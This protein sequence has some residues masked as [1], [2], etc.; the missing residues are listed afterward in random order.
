[1]SEKSLLKVFLND[2]P[3]VP[4]DKLSLHMYETSTDVIFHTVDHVL[5]DAQL[6]S[7]NFLSKDVS[8]R[9]FKFE[10]NKP[11]TLYSIPSDPVLTFH[12]QVYNSQK[13]KF[14]QEDKG[15]LLFE[16]NN[17]I[18]WQNMETVKYEFEQGLFS[19]FN[20]FFRPH[21]ILELAEKHPVLR[22]LA[23]E[24]ATSKRT[25]LDFF[26]TVAG[27]DIDVLIDQIYDEFHQAFVSERRFK[28]LAECLL[29]C[30][31]GID[32]TVDPPAPGDIKKDDEFLDLESDV[33]GILAR[34]ELFT[35]DQKHF[36]AQYKY[37]TKQML[38]DDFNLKKQAYIQ[39]KK[40]VRIKQ[41][42]L[43]KVKECYYEI[44]N[45]V[46]N[47]QASKFFLMAELIDHQVDKYEWNNQEKEIIG[48]VIILACRFAFQDVPP[49]KF[50][51]ELYNKW[52]EKPYMNPLGFN[53]F[54]ELLK[55]I[56]PEFTIDLPD[57][58]VS[59]E[60]QAI[61]M[62]H[63]QDLFGYRPLDHYKG[64]KNIEKPKELTVLYQ[65]LMRKFLDE[66]SI[67]DAGEITKSDVIRILDFSYDTNDP[68]SMLMLEIKH[69]S[70]DKQYVFAQD[71][72]LLSGW[73]LAL[74][75]YDVELDE[76]L[77]LLEH[78]PRFELITVYNN[79]PKKMGA[80][81]EHVKL[82]RNL[83]LQQT[84]LVDKHIKHLKECQS[85]NMLL[86]IINLFNC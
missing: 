23:M 73:L 80:V 48:K 4:Q 47:V 25:D 35:E 69:F 59:Y 65:R 36:I 17:Q 54:K 8:M 44:M 71:S 58:E 41:K 45:D 6:T 78:D 15:M 38:L 13:T 76:Q 11:I 39:R 49:L 81:E 19:H 32:I 60:S 74:A 1:M 24:I 56:K 72:D 77:F 53:H 70:D 67:S 85:K 10:L 66:I 21:V 26:V 2:K 50:Q 18:F 31:M 16:Q 64:L 61:F 86:N 14:V 83:I 22:E 55:K 28:H 51:I 84:D 3:V 9:A 79:S 43:A 63:V 33:I 5:D 34:Q 82:E 62:D 46:L 75:T 27:A 12:F 42:H 68:I 30:S 20:L 40:A 52:S 37:F 7:H 29:L 57:L